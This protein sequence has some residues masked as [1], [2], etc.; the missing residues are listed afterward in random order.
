[1]EKT[2]AIGTLFFGLIHVLLLWITLPI[3]QQLHILLAHF[4]P[5]NVQT[6]LVDVPKKS[7]IQMSFGF[8]HTNH[9]CPSNISELF[10]CSLYV[11]PFGMAPCCRYII[12]IPLNLTRKPFPKISRMAN[13]SSLTKLILS[14]CYICSLKCL[15]KLIIDTTKRNGTKVFLCLYLFNFNIQIPY[16][17]FLKKSS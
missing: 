17:W 9:T 15:F 7:Q 1:M 16:L 12:Q 11:L 2:K 8:P 4:F 14:I 6:L 5:T 3:Q 13:Q 10:L